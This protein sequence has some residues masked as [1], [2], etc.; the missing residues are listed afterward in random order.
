MTTS[1]LPAAL[2]DPRLLAPRLLG[3]QNRHHPPGQTAPAGGSAVV[4]LGDPGTCPGGGA[5]VYIVLDESLSVASA[6]GNDPLGRRHAETATAID[7][8]AAACRCRRD[9]VALVPFDLGSPGHVPPQQLNQFGVR[10]LHHG[11]QRLS[12]TPGMSSSLLPALA[13]VEQLASTNRG[14]SVVVVFSDF[15]LTDRDPTTAIHQLASFPGAV[16]AVVLGAAPPSLLSDHPDIET[17][18]LTPSSPDGSTALAVF[19]GLT[20]YRGP[21]NANQGSAAQA[22]GSLAPRKEDAHDRRQRNLMPRR[23]RHTHG[24][25]TTTPTREAP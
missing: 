20:H 12:T 3:A 11:L 25:L 1:I 24:M 13:H 8:L 17:T 5:V 2:V 10:R 14:S 9:R 18:R 23:S 15:L 19:N 4:S 16:H 21:R 7:H 6:G 22:A